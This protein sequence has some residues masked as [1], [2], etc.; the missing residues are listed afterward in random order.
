M[1]HILHFFVEGVHKKDCMAPLSKASGKCDEEVKKKFK[2]TKPLFV[3][4]KDT[5]VSKLPQFFDSLETWPTST[6]IK[7]W[8]CDLKFDTVPIFVPHAV[9]TDIYKAEEDI[10]D[11]Y[12]ESDDDSDYSDDSDK[13]KSPKR[14]RKTV[15]QIKEKLHKFSVEGC[16]HSFECA[17]SYIKMTYHDVGTMIDKLCLLKMLYQCFF[18]RSIQTIPDA[19][20]KN[21]MIQYGG[22]MSI[23][24]YR[25]TF[26][27]V[28]KRRGM[29]L[30]GKK[31]VDCI[32]QDG[33][34][35]ETSSYQ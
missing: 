30:A 24:A 23:T 26:K 11:H 21:N 13:K 10:Y 2:K 35:K 16:F 20:P 3:E 1:A 32:D 7:C 8:Y 18:K 15:A 12:S 29:E 25:K 28:L 31:G 5:I 27:L 34:W 6:N 9:A 33:C 17:S 14:H 22:D 4:E 19:M